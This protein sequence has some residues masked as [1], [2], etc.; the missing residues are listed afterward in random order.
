MAANYKNLAKAGIASLSLLFLAACGGEQGRFK[1]W[2]AEHPKGTKENYVRD[3]L[4]NR[5]DENYI[6]YSNR[7]ETHSEYGYH[8]GY[9][10]FSGKFEWHLGSYDVTNKRQ[11]TPEESALDAARYQKEKQAFHT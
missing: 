4:N 7:T 3:T 6:A 8:Y 11:N 5:R 10:W 1:D 9:N 2:Q